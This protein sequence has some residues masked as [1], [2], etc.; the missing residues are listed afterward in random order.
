MVVFKVNN[1]EKHLN[2]DLKLQNGASLVEFGLILLVLISLLFGI[3]DWGLYFF[4][5]QVI[6]NA[7]REGARAGIVSR[8][9][10]ISEGEIRNVVIDY[11][12]KYLVTFSGSKTPTVIVQRDC[13]DFGCN[14]SVQS[15]F[16]YNFLF[17]KNFSPSTII[18]QSNMKM[19]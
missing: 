2:S 18:V 4:N 11:S 13:P 10:R 7:T 8:E 14:L 3:V 16:D 9:V 15:S 1:M 19:E 17:F 5:R 6:T 12:E